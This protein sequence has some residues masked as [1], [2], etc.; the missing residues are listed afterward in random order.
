MRGILFFVRKL[1]KFFVHETDYNQK[2]TLLLAYLCYI[3]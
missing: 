1:N 3:L 2:Q